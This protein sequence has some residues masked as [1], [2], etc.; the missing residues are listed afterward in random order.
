VT[1]E[2]T[3]A[4]GTTTTVPTDLRDDP[5]SRKRFLR[6]MGTGG[7]SALAL[8]LASCGGNEEATKAALKAREEEKESPDLKVVVY[9]LVLE[10]LEADFYQQVIESG[11]VKDRRAADLVKSIGENEEEHVEAL[12]AA[13]KK[14]G[15]QPVAKLKT[16]FEDILEA[17]PQQ[18]L[19]TAAL[20][21]NLGAAAYLA[22]AVNI[23][24]KA[25]LAAALSIHSVEARHA[26]AL[27]KLAGNGFRGE[28]KLRGTIP[29]GA[30]AKPM[31]KAQVLTRLQPFLA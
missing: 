31:S 5:A 4:P 25:I 28:R 12:T 7:A 20:V 9:A 14:L 10:N 23:Q 18:I 15:G 30:F 13:V 6:M 24:D 8:V 19:K 21:E 16:K 2:P 1:P 3:N 17:G 11:M 29:D 27:N 22:Q 26:A